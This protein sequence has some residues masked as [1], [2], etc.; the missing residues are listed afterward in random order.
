MTADTAGG[1]AADSGAEDA[2]STECAGAE[3]SANVAAVDTADTVAPPALQSVVHTAH[4]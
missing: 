2:A 1:S 3:E 4:G